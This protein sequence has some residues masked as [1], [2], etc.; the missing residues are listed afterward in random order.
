MPVV[1][2]R[3]ALVTGGTRG[4]G[5]AIAEALVAEGAN[6]VINGRSEEKGARALAEL[7]AGDRVDFI[8]GNVQCQADCESLVEGTVERYGA[9]DIL[10]NNAGG[11]GNT[12][13]VVEMTDEAWMSSLNWNL[14]HPFWCTRAALRHM[15][16]RG[17]GRIIN[18]SSMYGKVPLPGVAH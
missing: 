8:A 1:Q 7:D 6:V 10:V 5:R 12:A 11:G 14:N 9:I 15:L 2:D 3:V 16:P 17:W 4:I 13:L 18:M